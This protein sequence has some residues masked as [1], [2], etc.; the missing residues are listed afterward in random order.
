M[1]KFSFVQVLTYCISS[2]SGHKNRK[3]ISLFFNEIGNYND[4]GKVIDAHLTTFG[5]ETKDNNDF[6]NME[7]KSLRFADA[8]NY[9]VTLQNNGKMSVGFVQSEYTSQIDSIEH[10]LY[11]NKKEKLVKKEMVRPTQERHINGK[12]A[13]VN[14]ANNIRYFT[15]KHSEF[16]DFI[17]IERGDYGQPSFLPTK[18]VSEFVKKIRKDE[19]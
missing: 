17:K 12:M 9:F 18:K 3:L 14:A 8:K 19:I 11:S 10:K 6:C 7:I 1:N 16:A 15:L 4:E 5:Q 13:D 2:P